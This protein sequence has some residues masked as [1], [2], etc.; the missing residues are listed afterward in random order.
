MKEQNANNKDDVKIEVKA[1][2]LKQYLEKKML[3]IMLEG[4]KNVSNDK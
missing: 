3:N 1:L 2:I 4:A